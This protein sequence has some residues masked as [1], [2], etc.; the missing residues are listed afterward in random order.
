MLLKSVFDQLINGQ[1]CLKN[2]N[3]WN[4]LLEEY[5]KETFVRLKSEKCNISRYRFD[6]YYTDNFNRVLHVFCVL[7]C[8]PAS[9]LDVLACLRA[10]H[11]CVLPCLACSS[12]FMF[13]CLA[14]SLAGVLTCS[15]AYVFVYFFCLYCS[16]RK[17]FW[18][19]KIVAHICIN[20]C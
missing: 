16:Y 18:N 3:L 8:L 14:F 11:A 5:G 19:Q 12:A 17:G 20:V 10:C 2:I 1:L 13:A 15:H 7:A 6:N 4:N 9:I